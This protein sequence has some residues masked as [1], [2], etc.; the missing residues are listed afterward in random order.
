MKKQSIRFCTTPDHVRLA[1]AVSGE[2]LPL[3]MSATWLSHLEYYWRSPFW[4]PWLDAFNINHKLLLHDSRGCG[5]SDRNAENISFETWVRDLEWV[6]EAAGFRKFA[7]VGTC[8]GGPIA[9]EYAARHPDRV[10]HLVL[11][12]T[13]AQDCLRR[14]WGLRP[15][16]LLQ[17][18]LDGFLHSR[19]VG[20]DHE[21]I[22]TG[23][24]DSATEINRP[25]RAVLANE[26]MDWLELR[27][28]GEA[29]AG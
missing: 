24:V 2:G 1:Y 8:W 19:A 22:E 17:N 4:R 7:M 23:L 18:S 26:A 11:Y 21:Q 15:C 16:L 25:E 9:I 20:P 3:V 10:S 12:G 14:G 5:L 27:R 28:G 29:Q 13:Y 6:I